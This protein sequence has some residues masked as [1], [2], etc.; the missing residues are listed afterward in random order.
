MVARLAAARA[1]LAL[2]CAAFVGAAVLSQGTAFG[3]YEIY[4]G[5]VCGNNCYVESPAAHTFYENDGTAVAPSL[6]I[7]CQLFNHSGVDIVTHGEGTC[8]VQYSGGAYVWA[9]VYNQ[10]G[11]TYYIRGVAYF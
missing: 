11:G 1:R 3:A 10:S 6:N 7:A 5:T 8:N 9:R 2:C 4:D